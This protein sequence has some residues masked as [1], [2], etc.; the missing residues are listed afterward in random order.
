MN[1]TSQ[2][3]S[4]QR[5]FLT[6]TYA[7]VITVLLGFSGLAVDVGYMQ[8]SKRR[9]QSAADAAAMGALRELELG[10]TSNI[11]PAGLNDAAL[12]GFTDGQN[13]TTVH[14]NQP[15]VHGTYAGNANAVEADISRTIPAFFMMIFGQNSVSVSAHS[16]ARTTTTEGSIGGCIFALNKTIRSG[17]SIN[18]TNM[19]LNSSCSA[20][21]ESTDSSAFTMGSGVTFNLSN[22]AHVGVVTPGAWSLNGQSSIMDASVT[23]NQPM[24]PQV[25]HLASDPG[26][27]FK[28]MPAPGNGGSIRSSGTVNYNKNNPPAENQLSAGIYCGGINF[29]DSNGVTYTLNPG[30]YV[31]AGG[32]LTINSSAIVAGTGVTFYN[33]I[34]TGWG[35]PSPQSF[36]PVTINGQAIV[37]LTAPTSGPQVGLIFFQDRGVVDSRVNKIVGGSSSTFDGA[38]Y[39]KNSP[40]TFA[41]TNSTN[42]YMVLVADII[43]INGNTTL[44]N[45]YSTLANPNPFAPY[46]TGG[47]LVE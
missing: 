16:V 14:I 28:D 11:S 29:G 6:V 7:L 17:L 31:L 46:S 47:G 41:G 15:P 10:H 34:G 23:P 38:L 27:P 26:D 43:S 8:W 4:K 18:G 25:A 37:N 39:F 44:G 9:T 35:C 42:G 3:G 19:R 45:N 36:A 24:T 30:V 33:S 32:G 22:H 5:G 21:V 1:Q 13:N 12:N 20:I 40:L 2:R